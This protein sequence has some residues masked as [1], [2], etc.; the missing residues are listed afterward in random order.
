MPGLERPPLDAADHLIEH[1]FDIGPVSGDSPISYQDIKAWSDITG[2]VLDGWEASTL[3]QMSSAY[4]AEYHAASEPN[5]QP[6]YTTS[7]IRPREVVASKLASILDRW[8]KQ[9]ARG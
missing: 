4:L 5:R 3:R 9:D 2:H 7:T 1:L 6:P 8:E